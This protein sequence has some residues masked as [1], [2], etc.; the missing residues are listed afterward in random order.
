MHGG[1]PPADEL[2]LL[3]SLSKPMFAAEDGAGTPFISSTWTRT[4]NQNYVVL[5]ISATIAWNLITSY[6]NDLP[7]TGRGIM[8]VA[9]TPWCGD[10][11]PYAAVWA[12]AH[13]T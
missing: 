7:Y 13:T 10:F 6:D 3:N 4:I 8:G 5:N 2:E 12:T 11:R 1:S 9:N